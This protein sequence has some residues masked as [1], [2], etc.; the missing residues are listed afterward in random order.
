VG[1]SIE[2]GKTF[3][4]K[5]G[6]EVQPQV[7]LQYQRLMFERFNDRNLVKVVIGPSHS[8]TARAGARVAWPQNDGAWTP[9]LHAHVLHGWSGTPSVRIADSS[10]ITGGTGSAVELAAGVSAR[11]GR[12]TSLSGAFTQRVRLGGSGASGKAGTVGLQYRF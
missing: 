9:Y 5:N 10:F 1:L 3:R 2:A 7:Q 12:S 6:L 8:L 11:L 4:L